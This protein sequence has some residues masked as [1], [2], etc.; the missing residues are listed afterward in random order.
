MAVFQVGGDV[1][2]AYNCPGVT[3]YSSVECYDPESSTWEPLK[4][5]MTICR[6]KSAVEVLN[7]KLYAIGGYS[8]DKREKNSAE[9]YDPVADSWTTIPSMRLSRWNSGISYKF[10]RVL[11]LGIGGR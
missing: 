10:L 5:I 8:D 6:S 9:C 11:V 2:D 1:Y 3:Y 7:G 4:N